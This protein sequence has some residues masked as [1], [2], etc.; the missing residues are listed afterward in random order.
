[1]AVMA[2]FANGNSSSLEGKL[3]SDPTHPGRLP[4]LSYR[5]LKSPFWT[6]HYMTLFFKTSP[7]WGGRTPRCYGV[8]S[9]GG[10]R[11]NE[12]A[13]ERGWPRNSF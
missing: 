1:M 5:Q 11:L 9:G 2:P 8:G 3:L 6:D 7:R 13:G 4:F 10:R 12:R